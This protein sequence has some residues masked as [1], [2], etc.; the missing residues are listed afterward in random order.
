MQ[1]VTLILT[2]EFVLPDDDETDEYYDTPEGVREWYTD[3]LCQSD[4]CLS[5]YAHVARRPMADPGDEGFPPDIAAAID[6]LADYGSARARESHPE[7]EF[8]DLLRDWIAGAVQAQVED[9]DYDQA[10]DAALYM[11]IPK[12]QS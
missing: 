12:G 10:S 7:Y 8:H 9:P 5:A 4:G 11:P 1:T 2:A 6:M 3:T